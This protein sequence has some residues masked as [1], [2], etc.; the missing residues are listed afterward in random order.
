MR[1][2]MHLNQQPYRATSSMLD[3]LTEVTEWL[4]DQLLCRTTSSMLGVLTEVTEW[5]IGSY[6]VGLQAACW[7]C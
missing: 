2:E 4:I 7:V 1:M 5:F 3:L 6:Y